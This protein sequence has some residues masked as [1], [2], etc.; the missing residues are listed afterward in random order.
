MYHDSALIAI[1]KTP[2]ITRK[3]LSRKGVLL[4]VVQ[5]VKPIYPRI[6]I[7]PPFAVKIKHYLHRKRPL[8]AAR[9]L[10]PKGFEYENRK[11]MAGLFAV[12]VLHRDWIFTALAVR[13]GIVLAG[14][15][16]SNKAKNH[17]NYDCYCL[18]AIDN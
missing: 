2:A 12:F 15:V 17:N 7:L 10:F 4:Y 6:Y 18:D 1:K 14:F 3:S 13:G 5:R 11:G 9:G 16:T 8:V